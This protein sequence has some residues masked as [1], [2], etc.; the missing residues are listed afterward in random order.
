MNKNYKTQLISNLK[1]AINLRLYNINLKFP[2]NKSFKNGCLSLVHIL[3][4]KGYIKE[5]KLNYKTIE[6]KNVKKALK[7]KNT[8]TMTLTKIYLHKSNIQLKSKWLM[9]NLLKELFYNKPFKIKKQRITRG[10]FSNLAIKKFNNPYEVKIKKFYN[11][12]QKPLEFELEVQL[13]YTNDYLS[14]NSIYLISKPS[15]RVFTSNKNLNKLTYFYYKKYNKEI[16]GLV[17][18]STSKGILSSTQALKHNIGGEVVCVV[19]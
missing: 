6:F 3:W 16:L 12:L 8:S 18:I 13:R 5:Y 17:I 7:K 11:I 4:E 10:S 15:R 14:I 19:F 1:S 9:Q 2:Y